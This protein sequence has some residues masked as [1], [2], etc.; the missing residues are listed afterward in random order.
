MELIVGCRNKD[1]LEALAQFLDR[2]SII[3]LTPDISEIAVDLLNTYRLSH[4]L[5]IP[6]AL[7]A[8]TALAFKYS[9]VTKNQRH[10]RFIDNLHLLSYPEAFSDRDTSGGAVR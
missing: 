7:I 8:S 10:F 5:L 2:F 4:G 3:H 6:D 9:F 1:E